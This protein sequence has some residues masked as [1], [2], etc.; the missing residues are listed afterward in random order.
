MSNTR[1]G[2]LSGSKAWLIRRSGS[3]Y[4]GIA[5]LLQSRHGGYKLVCGAIKRSSTR[6]SQSTQVIGVILGGGSTSCSCSVNVWG[7]CALKNVSHISSLTFCSNNL[8]VILTQE[9][10]NL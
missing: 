7:N 8:V 6:T 5:L 10:V 3:W 4:R 2:L 9:A 1:N